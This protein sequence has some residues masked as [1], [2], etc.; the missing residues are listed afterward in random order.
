MADKKFVPIDVFVSVVIEQREMIAALDV[1]VTALRMALLE[2]KTLSPQTEPG[3][4][5]CYVSDEAPR[6]ARTQD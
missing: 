4:K 1:T 6:E 3:S 5:S 2:Q